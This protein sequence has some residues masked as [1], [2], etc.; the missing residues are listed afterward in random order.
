MSKKNSKV[1]R[2]TRARRAA[3]KLHPRTTLTETL[4]TYSKPVNAKFARTRAEKLGISYS[5]Y[6]D[7][8]IQAHRQNQTLKKAFANVRAA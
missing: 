4:Y 6:V 7:R 5:E 8:L 1:V 3:K 2:I